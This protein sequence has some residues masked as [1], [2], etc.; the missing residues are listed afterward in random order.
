MVAMEN[1]PI[2]LYHDFC[3]STDR[4]KGN[5]SVIWE[6][7]KEQMSYLHQNGFAGVSLF[8]LVAEFE[9]FK[10]ERPKASGEKQNLDLRKKVILTFDDGDLSNYH[11]VLPVLKEFGFSATFFV[12]INEIGKEGR[13]DWTMI[14]D[15]SKNGMDVGSHGLTHSFLTGHNSY[16]LLNELLMSKQILEKYIRKRVNFLS[17]PQGFYNKQVLSI[18]KDVG[19]KAICI[20]DAGYNDFLSDD[21]FVLKRFTM[22]RNYKFKA[23]KSIVLGAPPVTIN[24]LEGTRSLLRNLLG[25][26]VYDKLKRL[27]VRGERNQEL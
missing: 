6:N 3:S 14:Y 15:L 21:L 27:S 5:F 1:I 24:A 2:L 22:R 23:F 18:A 25:Y 12:T 7:F 11:F 4:R 20:S 8:R 19:F 16:A 17:I 9:Y 10:G 13:M 26:Q